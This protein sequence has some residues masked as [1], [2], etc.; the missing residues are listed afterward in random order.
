[1]YCENKRNCVEH[2]FRNFV[3]VKERNKEEDREREVHIHTY[4]DIYLKK[5]KARQPLF[6]VIVAYISLTLLTF[7][8]M[9]YLLPSPVPYK[10]I[11]GKEEEY[12][13]EE[14]S[15]AEIEKM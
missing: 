15:R 11:Y 10:Y 6:S 5:N 2:N 14:Q 13:E 1:M 7:V 9:G 4:K 3:I 12:Q 8:S